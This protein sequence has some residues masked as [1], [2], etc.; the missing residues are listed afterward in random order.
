MKSTVKQLRERC[1]AVGVP[2]SG[3]KSDI[4]DRLLESGLVTS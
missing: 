2:T 1:K 4:V 3:K